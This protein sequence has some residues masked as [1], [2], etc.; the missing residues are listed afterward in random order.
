MCKPKLIITPKK[1]KYLG[2]YFTKQAKDM[3]DK[4]Q[5]ILMK[6]QRQSKHL[7]RGTM[8]MNWKDQPRKDVNTSL[9]T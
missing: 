2:M 1:T 7:K 9:I 3:Y 4:N 6:T 5:K 8:L